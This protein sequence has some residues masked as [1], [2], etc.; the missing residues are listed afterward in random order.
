[1][2]PLPPLA[3]LIDGA[4]IVSLPLVTR[5]RGVDHREVMLLRGPNGWTEF[6]PFLEYDDIESATWLAAALEYG[7][8]DPTRYL[9]GHRPGQRN[10]ARRS[11][12][13]GE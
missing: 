6:S 10:G 12:R 1:M 5:F 11:A 13:R 8:G 3:D 9:P 4:R 2:T 7:W